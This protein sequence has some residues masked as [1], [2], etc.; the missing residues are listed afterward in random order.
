ISFA[1]SEMT[2][3]VFEAWIYGMYLILFFACLS[4]ASTRRTEGRG[5]NSV[6]L[7]TALLLFVLITWH[8]VLDAV[9]LFLAYNHETTREAD[10]YYSNP[11]G[12]LGVMRT[13]LYFGVT[14]VSDAFMLYRCWVVW[15]RSFAI[16]ALPSVLFLA[17]IATGIPGL[18]F[19]TRSTTS[20]YMNGLL[21]VTSAFFGVTMA[22]NNVSTLLIAIRV[23]KG[24]RQMS[25]ITSTTSLNKLVV[26]VLESGTENYAGQYYRM[27]D[28]FLGAMY[29]ATLVL[30]LATFLSKSTSAYNVLINV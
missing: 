12:L 30:V 25:G 1:M 16:I 26:I 9:M 4:V 3:L 19:L 21:P 2:A 6:F 14:L 17:D 11:S 10:I 28:I 27:I 8:F 7:T 13:G 20:Y 29:S 5:F 22:T 23:W 15:N 18:L 24:Q